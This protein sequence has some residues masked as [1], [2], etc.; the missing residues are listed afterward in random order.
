MQ[1]G[2]GAGSEVAACASTPKH[3]RGG[4][5]RRAGTVKT[6]AR[7]AMENDRESESERA[8]ESRRWRTHHVTRCLP[9]S[10]QH[11]QTRTRRDGVLFVDSKQGNGKHARARACP[12][13]WLCVGGEGGHG[14]A[15]SVSGPARQHAC[16]FGA[17]ACVRIAHCCRCGHDIQSARSR[18]IVC[19][20]RGTQR[21]AYASHASHQEGLCA[22]K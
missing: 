17:S 3:E 12:S 2:V 16:P 11:T 13:V 14:D 10:L 1:A 20:L 22:G 18:N 7:A 19:F 4:G 6:A 15:G 21:L 9:S 5:E 8:S